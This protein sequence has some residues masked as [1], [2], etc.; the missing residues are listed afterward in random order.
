MAMAFGFAQHRF[1]DVIGA[2]HQ[3][4]VFSCVQTPYDGF[5]VGN[6][7]W[8]ISLASKGEH[9]EQVVGAQ[10]NG[11]GGLMADKP[12]RPKGVVISE[13]AAERVL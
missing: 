12:G 10:A 13:H 11:H 8:C 1:A 3:L 6:E 7:G 5:V 4:D 2:S 9:A